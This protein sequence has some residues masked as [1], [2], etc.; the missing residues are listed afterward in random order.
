MSEA[1]PASDLAE[2]P[3]LRRRLACF[4][5]EGVLLF[6]VVMI[7]GLTWSVATEQRHALVGQQGLQAFLFIVLGVYF[8]WFWS[9]GG[10][11]LA[12]QTWHIR[13]TRKDGSPVSMRRALCR[14][15]LAWLWFLPALLTLWATGLRGGLAASATVVAG[16]LIYAGLARWFPSRQYL[17]DEAC[18]TRLVVSHPKREASGR[19]AFR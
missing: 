1:P 19:G 5:Y 15:L 9:H 2:T 16:I 11:T 13:L 8:V 3:G 17:H 12:M 14:Y 4:V 10:Q 6:G 7:A 18:G